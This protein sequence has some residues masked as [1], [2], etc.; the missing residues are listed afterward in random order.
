MNTAPI[1]GIWHSIK[2]L[3]TST[4]HGSGISSDALSLVRSKKKRGRE[5]MA[6]FECGLSHTRWQVLWS[7][8]CLKYRG[9]SDSGLLPETTCDESSCDVI[10]GILV[11]IW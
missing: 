5:H 8:L 4:V 6:L 3:P 1:G 7:L 9:Y 2:I 11:C 10:S